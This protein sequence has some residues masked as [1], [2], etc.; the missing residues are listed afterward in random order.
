MEPKKST[1]WKFVVG[2]LAIIVL[3]VGGLLGW[4]LYQL[5]SGREA[6][7]KFAEDLERL[8]DE[9]YQ[10]Q[11][12]DTVGGKTPQETLRMYIEAVEKGDY[13]LASK[14]FVIEKQEEEAVSLKRA[15]RE[16]IREYLLLLN[17]AFKNQGNY[18]ADASYFSIDKPILVRMAKYPGGTW[19]ILEI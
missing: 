15:G 6:V 9:L 11:L 10:K 1:Y 12:A 4:N 8:G 19:K 2:F 7:N 5:R 13:E 3:A 16:F 18:T 17:Q 14:Y